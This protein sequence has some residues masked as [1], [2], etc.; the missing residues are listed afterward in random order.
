[1]NKDKLLELAREAADDALERLPVGTA[2]R[3]TAYRA[4]HYM[5]ERFAALLQAQAAQEPEWYGMG[6][7]DPRAAADTAMMM[8]RAANY[9]REPV[10]AER[11]REAA[12]SLDN[13]A[14]VLWNIVGD[15]RLKT[16]QQPAQATDDLPP[17]N[18]GDRQWLHYNPNTDDLVE[19]VQTYARKAIALSQR[20][21]QAPALSDE[22]IIEMVQEVV[23]KDGFDVQDEH[24]AE[25]VEEVSIAVVRAILSQP[26]A[27]P[28]SGH[29]SL[30]EEVAKAQAE[31]ATWPEEKRK[32]VRLEGHDPYYSTQPQGGSK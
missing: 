14:A 29:N 3:L 21:E 25:L 24:Q 9:M 19:W 26:A 23:E 12:N 15:N 28:V 20:Q 22:Q 17:I 18:D 2:E 5:M 30:L 31:Y 27:A 6:Q 11:M 1:M 7:I 10:D 8:N 16:A 13:H 4:L 32:S